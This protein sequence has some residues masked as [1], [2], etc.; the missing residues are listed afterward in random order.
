MYAKVLRN[1]LKIAAVCA[2]GAPFAAYAQMGNQPYNYNSNNYNY[3]YDNGYGYNND[4]RAATPYSSQAGQ[5]QN[6]PGA[7]Y[8][9][10]NG[11]PPVR[12]NN[13]PSGGIYNGPGY[14]HAY[15]EGPR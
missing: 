15:P 14:G 6:V 11:G 4:Y 10:A 1:A 7:S 2:M 9:A 8:S 3:R 5:Y 12:G 13:L